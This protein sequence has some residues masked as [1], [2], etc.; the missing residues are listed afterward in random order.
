LILDALADGGKDE[1]AVKAF[2]DASGMAVNPKLVDSFLEA[3]LNACEI[4][5]TGDGN[6]HRLDK[7]GV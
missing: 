2:I 1:E 5:Q 3:L 4:A 6:Y 7:E